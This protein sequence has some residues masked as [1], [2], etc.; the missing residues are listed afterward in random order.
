MSDIASLELAP[1]PLELLRVA[2]RLFSIHGLDGVSTREI[3]RAAGQKN[4]SAVAYH[5]GSKEALVQRIL[6]Y[7]LLP[8]NERRAALVTALE[9]EGRTGDLRSL[10]HALAAPFVQEL[11]QDPAESHYIGFI[12][13]L[14]AGDN[15]ATLLDDNPSRNSATREVGAYLVQALPHL[16]EPLRTARLHMLGAQLSQIVA[17]WD[18]QRREAEPLFDAAD[19]PWMTENLVDVLTAGLA[20]PVSPDTT[21]ALQLTAT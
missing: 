6:D 10:V 15:G 13:R 12:S 18:R 21:G 2:E 4:H 9:A 19:I 11:A 3:A 8:V 20:C 1:T 16:P 17:G 14:Y 5:F 7:R